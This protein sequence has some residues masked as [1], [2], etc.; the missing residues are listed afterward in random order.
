MGSD[1]VR[2]R[3]IGITMLTLNASLLMELK[4]RVPDFPD[5]SGG[6]LVHKIVVGSPAF[7]SVLFILLFVCLFMLCL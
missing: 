1:A 7:K 5:I 2:R 4:N 3:F 6:V